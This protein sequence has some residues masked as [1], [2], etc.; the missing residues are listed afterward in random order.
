MPLNHIDNIVVFEVNKESIE[1]AKEDTE[2]NRNEIA[3]EN[4]AK[5]NCLMEILTNAWRNIT[6]FHFKISEQLLKVI[7]ANPL[8][9]L[10]I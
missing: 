2:A 10:Y 8:F 5:T 1:S 3:I 6:A 4:I 7:K 9:T